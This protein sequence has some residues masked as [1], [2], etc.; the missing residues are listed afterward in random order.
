MYFFYIAIVFCFLHVSLGGETTTTTIR[1]E[2]KDPYV[3]A[4]SFLSSDSKIYIHAI[5]EDVGSSISYDHKK[6]LH[7]IYDITDVG[8]L[9]KL[10]DFFFKLLKY[11]Q[12]SRYELARKNPEILRLNDLKCV[13][14]SDPSLCNVKRHRDWAHTVLLVVNFA[15]LRMRLGNS[16]LANRSNGFTPDDFFPPQLMQF[17]NAIGFIR[18]ILDKKLDKGDELSVEEKSAFKSFLVF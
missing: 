17:D 9:E 6:H 10:S 5:I 12:F 15:L 4:M 18:K 7:N 13:S 2:L 3:E 8:K 14:K 11:L 1:L 16:E